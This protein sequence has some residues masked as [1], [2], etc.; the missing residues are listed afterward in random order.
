MYSIIFG[1]RHFVTKKYIYMPIFVEELPKTVKFGL[2]EKFIRSDKWVDLSIHISPLEDDLIMKILDSDNERL[3]AEIS[4]GKILS[5]RYRKIIRKLESLKEIQDYIISGKG[6]IY[7][8]SLF[9][10]PKGSNFNQSEIV[11]NE[12]SH[13]MRRF[14]FKFYRPYYRQ[15]IALKNL[16]PTGEHIPEKPHYLHTHGLSAFFPFLSDY[17]EMEGGIFYGINERNGSPVFLNRWI[18]PSS[19]YII[20]GTTGFGK[21]YFVKLMI[22]REVINDPSLRIFIIDPMGEYSSLVKLLGGTNVKVGEKGSEINLLD[23]QGNRNFREKVSRLRNIFS[24]I[25]NLNK[26]EMAILDSILTSL[27]IKNGDPKISDLLDLLKEEQGGDLYYSMERL[28]TGSLKN[29]NSETRVNLNRKIIS[30]DLSNL[31]DEYL[32]LYMAI[33]L[34]HIYGKVSMDYEKKLVVVDEAWK[35]LKNEYSAI[36]ID[37]MFRHVRRWKCGMNVISQKA[38]DFLENPYGR[39]MANNSLFHIIFKHPSINES[40]RHFYKLNSKEE[41]Y[42]INAE[43]PKTGKFSQ[44]YFISHPLRFP[45]KVVSTPEENIFITT[46][47]DELREIEK[48]I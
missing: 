6:H 1:K 20:T 46:D 5:S 45:L 28:F 47:P 26:N 18:F 8:F 42:I 43:K 19:H 4:E 3:N 40:V 25:L 22:L 32:T 39:S 35:L 48:L 12:I 36:F 9:L 34:D 37:S 44:A 13:E 17:I 23:L 24:I 2:M 21:S 38:D 33:I 15:E 11:Y 30:F 29:L 7:E 27:Y 14:I 16:L 10:F 41:E 31:S